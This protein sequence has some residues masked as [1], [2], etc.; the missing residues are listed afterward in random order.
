[1]AKTK[2]QQEEE[3]KAAEKAAG[4]AVTTEVVAVAPV[5]EPEVQP[6]PEPLQRV[7]EMSLVEKIN[8]VGKYT[9]VER[10]ASEDAGDEVVYDIYQGKTLVQVGAT[11]Q[12]IED[13]Y[14]SP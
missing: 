2:R 9:V 10:S 3:A 8:A 4:E 7:A 14:I 1:M 13:F 11:L 6:A 5:T 12:I